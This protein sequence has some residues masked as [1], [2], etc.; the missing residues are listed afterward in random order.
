MIS[1]VKYRPLVVDKPTTVTQMPYMKILVYGD[2]LIKAGQG[3]KRLRRKL[4]AKYGQKNKLYR[5]KEN[6]KKIS[7]SNDII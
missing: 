4:Y 7:C 2:M 1:R 5:R 6:E 3:E